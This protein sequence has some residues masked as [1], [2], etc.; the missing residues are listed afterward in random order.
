MCTRKPRTVAVATR[1]NVLHRGRPL[2][3]HT[4]MLGRVPGCHALKSATGAA[5][6]Q[7]PFHRVPHPCCLYGATGR[8]SCPASC[9]LF[10]RNPVGLRP[11]RTG[12]HDRSRLPRRFENV[13]VD[14]DSPCRFHLLG[15]IVEEQRLPPR[16]PQLPQT[17]ETD[18]FIRFGATLLA[19]IRSSHQSHR[20]NRTCRGEFP[21]T[22]R[23][24]RITPL[25]A[26]RLP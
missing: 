17:I 9:P 16:E 13:S 26:F 10:P 11:A 20:G 5:W 22:R 8:Q 1:T 23:S 2:G 25:S 4:V 6:S 19:R 15:T 3:M 18:D 24:R 14:A 21:V 12:F 7:Y